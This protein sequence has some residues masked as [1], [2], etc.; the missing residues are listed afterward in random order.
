[1]SPSEKKRP[2]AVIN[3]ES[4]VEGVLSGLFLSF[5]GFRVACAA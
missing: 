1:M 3:E 4:A 2:L 5:I